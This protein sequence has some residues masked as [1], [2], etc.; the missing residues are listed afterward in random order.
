[1]KHT[2]ALAT[3][4]SRQLALAIGLSTLVS[5]AAFAFYAAKAHALNLDEEPIKPLPPV[6]VLDAKKVDLGRR[7]FNDPRLSKNGD[8]SCA[9]CHDF[10]NYGGADPRPRSIGTGG[11]IGA[12]NSPTIF[13]SQFNFAQLWSGAEPTLEAVVSR[14][15]KGPKLF[16]TTFPD[17]IAKLERD[18]LYKNQFK[19][20]YGTAASEAN[21][22][23]A[24]ATFE[25]T[26]VT[27]SRFDKY[28][29]G[30]MTA[31]TDEE[32][33]GYDRFK[34]LGCIACHQGINVGGN[35]YQKFGIVG[36]YLTQR[37]PLTEADAGR[38]NVTKDEADRGVFRV[39]SLR[40]VALTAPYFH[41][42]SAKT[43]PDAVDV[44]IKYQL[45][46]TVAQ[47]DRDALVSFLRTLSADP[48]QINAIVAQGKK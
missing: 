47:K 48:E 12:I 25:R 45:G 14:V 1:M 36:D 3:S 41:D 8:V 30:D 11:A 33:Y 17:I 24:I 40:N 32:K 6:P 22:I 18:E 46:R 34:N 26:L 35:M 38:F 37:G 21:I 13:N 23:D 5:L 31:I 10:A 9:S 29:R 4:S 42:G 2:T 39:P 16:A 19:T 7:L 28:L 20:A 43:L 15:V 27:P 44:M